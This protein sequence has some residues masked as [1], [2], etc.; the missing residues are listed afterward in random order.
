MKAYPIMILGGGLTGLTLAN[1]LQDQQIPFLLLEARQRLGGRI[2][3]TYLDKN[4]PVEMGATWLGKR[5]A[6]AKLTT[7]SSPGASVSVFPTMPLGREEKDPRAVSAP[8]EKWTSTP[9]PEF[10]A[11]EMISSP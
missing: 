6:T 4:A 9:S 10:P 11:A 3:T 5:H 8:G 2:L 7:A 1:L